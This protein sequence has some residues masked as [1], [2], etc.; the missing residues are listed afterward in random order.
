MD[1]FQ[2]NKPLSELVAR[3]KGQLL[4]GNGSTSLDH[5]SLHELSDLWV[6]GTDCEEAGKD[7]V[8]IMSATNKSLSEQA[9]TEWADKYIKSRRQRSAFGE[10]LKD[11]LRGIFK[12]ARPL[13]KMYKI[14]GFERSKSCT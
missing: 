14:V 6:E 4:L 7:F 3:G 10:E 13:F 8:T 5:E 12:G 1:L 9:V 11:V 2:G